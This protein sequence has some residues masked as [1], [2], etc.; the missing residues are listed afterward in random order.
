MPKKLK[1]VNLRLDVKASIIR[2][3]KPRL[4]LIH[5]LAKRYAVVGMAETWICDIDRDLQGSVKAS[6]FG[7]R[8]AKPERTQESSNHCTPAGNVQ[9][10]R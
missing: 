3:L 6:A 4:Q 8:T 5:Q 10:N 1:E 9:A 7:T 2:G